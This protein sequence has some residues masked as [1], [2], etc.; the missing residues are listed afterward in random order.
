M[1]TLAVIAVIAVVCERF[2]PGAGSQ[3]SHVEWSIGCNDVTRLENRHVGGVL[4]SSEWLSHFKNQSNKL[5]PNK[6][7]LTIFAIEVLYRREM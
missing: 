7:L 6:P 4:C 2:S 5:S 3:S 1:A